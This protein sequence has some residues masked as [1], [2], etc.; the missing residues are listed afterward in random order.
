LDGGQAFAA[1]V[2]GAPAATVDAGPVRVPFDDTAV[3]P[4]ALAA[5]ARPF[6]AGGLRLP[7]AP[8]TRVA[9]PARGTALALL[10]ADDDHTPLAG[11]RRIGRCVWCAIDLGSAA[12]DLL[13]E[14]AAAQAPPRLPGVRAR[15]HGLAE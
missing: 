4:P 6:A 7:H 13:T 9:G 12:A 15:L 5:R 10:F 2:L 1:A 14:Q 3:W 8:F 11:V